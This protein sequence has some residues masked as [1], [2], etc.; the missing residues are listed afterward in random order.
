[1][2]TIGIITCDND[3]RNIPHLLQQIAEKVEVEHEVIIIDNRDK[4]K[5]DKVDWKASF[6][7]GYNAFQF[8]ARAEIV[9]RAKGE[10]IWFLD[11][12]DEIATVHNL[13]YDEDIV[14]FSYASYPEGVVHIPNQV[15]KEDVFTFEV[16]TIIRPVL[17]NKFIRT[18]L[19]SKEFVEKA[20][21]YRMVTNE[22]ILWCYEALRHASSVRIVDEVIYW[23]KEGYSNRQSVITHDVIKHLVTGFNDMLTLMRELITDDDFYNKTIENTCCYLLSIIVYSDDFEASFQ[24]MMKLLPEEHF[25]KHVM[26]YVGNRTATASNYRTVVEMVKDKY[27]DELLFPEKTIQVK[28]EDG[29]V[30]E[31]TF[32]QTII[33]ENEEKQIRGC[34]NHTLSI[35]LLVYDGNT[36]YLEQCVNQ[37][38]HNVRVQYEIVIVDNREHKDFKIEYDDAIVVDAKGNV[39]ILDGRR[40]GF[41]HSNNE[42]VWFIDIDDLVRITRDLP[43]GDED[44]IVHPFYSDDLDEVTRN[45]Y[46]F[47]IG[48]TIT[49]DEFFEIENVQK[50]S[51]AVWNKWFK[52][53]VLEKVFKEVP[54]FFCVYHEDNIITFT[55]LLFAES[56][57]FSGD[58]AIYSHIITPE[59]VT[60]SCISTEKAVDTLFEGY[61]EV[62]AYMEKHFKKYK[63][64]TYESPANIGFYVK[65]MERS[66]EEIKPYFRNKLDSLFGKEAVNKAIESAE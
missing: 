13:D 17:W 28:Y 48:G 50:M 19:F 38:R 57:K 26:K 44:I 63:E 7:Y 49:K 65:V 1:M 61:D 40:L 9:E 33:F 39:G 21:N 66:A 60:L 51:I 31:H 24:L 53:E 47:G 52:R 36:K 58:D 5:D 62:V 4:F 56:V 59:S 10:Y 20:K 35:V 45:F 2:L 11:G 64:L 32:R 46:R 12:D 34:W 30:R 27:G 14:A 23:H 43:Y 18:S 29:T 16:G 3:Y 37:I 22:D 25:K 15:F 8:S 6:S 54:S 41:E 42:Y 55:S